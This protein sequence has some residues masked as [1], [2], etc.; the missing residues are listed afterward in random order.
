MMDEQY[1][2][3]R[4]RN[5][6]PDVPVY[7]DSKSGKTPRWALGLVLTGFFVLFCALVITVASASPMFTWVGSAIAVQ[8]WIAAAIVRPLEA[9]YN[10]LRER[11]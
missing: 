6:M 9:I 5:A 1:R 7:S 2:T 3:D 8:C 10:V 4:A 11:A